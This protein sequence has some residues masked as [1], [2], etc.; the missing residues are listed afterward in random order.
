MMDTQEDISRY[1]N[2][3]QEDSNFVAPFLSGSQNTSMSIQES[4]SEVEIVPS[5][6]TKRDGNF[7]VDEDNLLVSAWLKLAW[8]P[9]MNN[10]YKTTCFASS[11]S[12]QWGTMNR[13]TS[14]FAGFMAK[15]EVRNQSGATNQMKSVS[16]ERSKGLPQ[17]PSSIDQVGSNDDD[18]MMLERPIGRKAKKAKQ[19]RTNGDKESHEQDKEAFHIKVD[20]VRMDA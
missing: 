17:T 3:L 6:P 10:T 13:E 14:K 16:K 15:V 9:C 12:S 2:F 19:K 5:N 7:S 4:L 8:M 20:R 18:T 11:L 1:A